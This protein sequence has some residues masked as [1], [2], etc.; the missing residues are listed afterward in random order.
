VRYFA[1]ERIAAAVLAHAEYL[2]K[3]LLAERLER[4]EALEGGSK[5]SLAG[6][7]IVVMVERVAG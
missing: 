6:E 5:L 7:E 4:C 2:K 3:E 1:G